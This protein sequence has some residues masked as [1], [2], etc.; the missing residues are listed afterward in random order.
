MLH[1]DHRNLREVTAPCDIEFNKLWFNMLLNIF[2]KFMNQPD[3]DKQ[4]FHRLC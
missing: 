3:F 1:K 2:K 4:T